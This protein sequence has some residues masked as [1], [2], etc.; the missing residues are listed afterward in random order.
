[1]K[2]WQVLIILLSKSLNKTCKFCVNQDKYIS[3]SKIFWGT[4][5]TTVFYSLG[6]ELDFQLLL[7]KLIKEVLLSDPLVYHGVSSEK[8]ETF[9]AFWKAK[10]HA[11]IKSD[12]YW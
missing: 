10:K 9:F 11:G 2:M 8:R 1:M 5:L 12:Q 7:L 3:C 4:Y 6:I